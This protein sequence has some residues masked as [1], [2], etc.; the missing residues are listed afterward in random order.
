MNKTRFNL[1]D[2]RSTLHNDKILNCMK[3]LEWIPKLTCYIYNL[4]YLFTKIIGKLFI[5]I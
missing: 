5:N 1:L 4:K 2:I 3:N